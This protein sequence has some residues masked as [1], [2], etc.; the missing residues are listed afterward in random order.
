MLSTCGPRG[1]TIDGIFS[2][3]KSK[4]ADNKSTQLQ[5]MLFSLCRLD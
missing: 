1:L 4:S 3:L 5:E 2:G